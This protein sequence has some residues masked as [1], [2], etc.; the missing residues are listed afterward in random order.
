MPRDGPKIGEQIGSYRLTAL[1]GRG[2]MAA[3]FLAEHTRLSRR[4]AVKVLSVQTALDEVAVSRFLTEARLISEID[5]PGVVHILDVVEQQEPL[6]IAYVME[7]VDGPTLRRELDRRS[8]RPVEVARLGLQL[9]EALRAIH[10]RQVVHRDL[11][12]SNILL[13]GTLDDPGFPLAKLADFGIAKAQDRP[14]PHKTATGLIIGTP[15]YMAPEQVTG[16]PI[17][18]ATDIYALGELLYEMFTGDRVFPEDQ[19]TSLRMKLDPAPPPLAPLPFPGSGPIWELIQSC[20]DPEAHRRPSHDVIVEVLQTI[21]AAPVP[22]GFVP[23]ERPT[24][25]EHTATFAGPLFVEPGLAPEPGLAARPQDDLHRPEPRPD[26]VTTP[27]PA[28][29]VEMPRP[30]PSAPRWPLA[31]LGLAVA[32]GL[33]LLGATLVEDEGPTFRAPAQDETARAVGPRSEPA[34]EAAPAAAPG[35]ATAAPGPRGA[36]E[37]RE[38]ASA[39]GARQTRAAAPKAGL[40]AGAEAPAAPARLQFRLTTEPAGARVEDAET[41]AELGVTPLDLEIIEGARRQVRLSRRGHR[42]ERVE[43]DGHEDVVVRLKRRPRRR[44]RPA[45]P[46]KPA[47]PRPAKPK[48]EDLMPW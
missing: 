41:G 48:S 26:P 37:A 16:E 33:G 13:T 10:A 1:L 24:E 45:P 44:A 34:V 39:S 47:E 42:P 18:A 36:D 6:R 35:R 38:G 7:H 17:T 11:K 21:D 19:R 5:H 40:R 2:G 25:I 20:L 30:P 46:P 15:T 4:A 31:A 29:S 12:P 3:V 8:L 32:L 27:G 28:P 9:T 43:L 23:P 14:A 22:T